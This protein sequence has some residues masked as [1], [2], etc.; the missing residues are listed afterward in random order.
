MS[1]KPSSHSF[2]VLEALFVTF[3]WSSSWVLIKLGLRDMP[4][5]TFA[6]LRYFGA[7]LVLLPFACRSPYRNAL[8]RLTRRDWLELAVLGI[9]YYAATQGAQFASLALIPAVTVSLLLNFTTALVVLLGILFL[10]EYPSRWQ[11]GGL[12]LFLAGLAIYFIPATL[13]TDQ[14]VG[15]GIAGFGLVANAV[16]SILGRRV[17]Q[18]LAIGPLLVTTVSMGVGSLGLLAAGVQV[19]GMPVLSPG[20][21]LLIAWL[22]VI[23][24]A[25]A[26]TLWN[27]SLQVLSAME[28]SIINGT[29]LFQIAILAWVFIGE[30]I[31]PQQGIGMVVAAAGV[32][33]VQIC[34]RARGER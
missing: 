27:H 3:L 6:G 7:F 5:L 31:S 8:R 24:T 28:S 22:A 1:L 32:L 10:H 33:V 13:A 23:N 18:A 20:N 29:M 2:A 30:R 21:W 17:N 15:L 19:Q 26:F 12:G 11:W 34:S 25:V 4:S 14:W 9:V 16:S